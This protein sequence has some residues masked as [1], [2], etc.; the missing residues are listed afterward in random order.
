MRKSTYVVVL[1]LILAS[2]LIVKPEAQG[3][4]IFTTLRVSDTT[5]AGGIG[6]GCLPGSTNCPGTLNTGDIQM[7]GSVYFAAADASPLT[8]PSLWFA[9]NALNFSSG[10]SGYTWY[11]GNG[12]ASIMSLSNPTAGQLGLT[13]RDLGTSVAP[14]V[15]VGFSNNANP[16]G[17]VLIL[18]SEGAIENYLWVDNSASPGMLRITST[19]F[20]NCTTDTSGTVVGTQAS[21][22][23]SKDVNGLFTDS[24]AALSTI[25]RTPVYSFKYKGNQYNGQQFVGIITDYSPEFGMDNGKSFNP[26][27][28]FGFTVES[29]KA[30]QAEIN[31]L[32]KQVSELRA[33]LEAVIAK[34]EV[35]KEPIKPEVSK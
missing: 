8:G 23:A 28:A 29:F 22:L 3:P 6:I 34:P 35:K 13:T 21:S 4:G 12:V 30:Q 31:D 27:N 26:V 14:S 19:S 5:A 32:K 2:L 24:R 17:G 1:L 15:R 9:S 33:A 25:L 20:G 10:S 11:T 7:I 16:C 18:T